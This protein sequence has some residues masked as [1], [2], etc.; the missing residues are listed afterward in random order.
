MAAKPAPETRDADELANEIE[1]P[2]EQK[3]LQK[4]VKELE[5]R[6]SDLKDSHGELAVHLQGIL[7]AAERV[8]PLK[9]VYKGTKSAK[10]DSPVVAV[11]HCTDWHGGRFIPAI[12]VE[13]FNAFDYK[14]MNRRLHKNLMPRF[15]ATVEGAR[16]VMKIDELHILST[17]DMCNGALHGEAATNEFDELEQPV[18][19]GYSWAELVRLLA[20]HYKKVVIHW[21]VPDNHGRITPKIESHRP[22]NSLNYIC[23]EFAKVATKDIKNVEW[24][25]YPGVMQVVEINEVRYLLRH[26]HGMT[27]GAG[28]F[29]G[30]PYYAFERAVGKEARRRLVHF[31]GA[32]FH[33]MITGHFH[34]ATRAFDWWIGPSVSGTDT[35]DHENGRF[36]PPG[37]CGW[38]IHPKRGELNYNMFDL[39]Q[40]SASG[41]ETSTDTDGEK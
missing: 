15:Q 18:R 33:R 1:P 21:V 28:G 27:K 29:G 17:G 41:D 3:Y 8:S 12:E 22:W 35:H 9:Q 32:T 40:D 19:I 10:V 20:P 25:I 24:N 7:N 2:A 38:L 31:E 4:R 30:I 36:H 23:G 37:Q 26:G 14:I 5:K 16:T 11:L 39:S 34:V 13:D 6:Y